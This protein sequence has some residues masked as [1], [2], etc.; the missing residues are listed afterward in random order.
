MLIAAAG[1]GCQL[2]EPGLFCLGSRWQWP[3]EAFLLLPSPCSCPVPHFWVGR[4]APC[5]QRRVLRAAWGRTAPTLRGRRIFTSSLQKRVS[6]FEDGPLWALLVGLWVGCVPTGPMRGNLT[7]GF[8]DQVPA[9]PQLHP[10]SPR[11]PPQTVTQ[12]TPSRGQATGHV[13]LLKLKLIHFKI[14]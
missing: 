14:K 4:R 8:H 10:L 7:G 9:G 13:C 2:P 1:G 6:C 12:T 11:H 5:T 3:P